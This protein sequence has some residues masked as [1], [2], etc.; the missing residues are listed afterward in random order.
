MDEP[1][2]KQF[3]RLYFRFLD[4]IRL[5]NKTNKFDLF[6][7]KNYMLRKTNPKIIIDVWTNSI[8][9]P[10]YDKAINGDVSFFMDGKFDDI[11]SKE[12]HDYINYFKEL[13]S[14]MNEENRPIFVDYVKQ[15]TALSH[16][17]L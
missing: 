13:Y 8:T 14:L 15:L 3:K 7:K 6:Y 11:D 16:S 12:V 4:F 2:W 10:Y 17:N 5:H 1:V 9:I